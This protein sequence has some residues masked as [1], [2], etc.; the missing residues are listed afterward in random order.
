MRP[1]TKLQVFA[2]FWPP[3]KK[4]NFTT[5]YHPPYYPDYFLSP[6]LKTKLKGLHF[7]DVAE[8]QESV[9][10]ELKKVQK[11]E[12]SAALQKLYDRANPVYM[13]MELILNIKKARVFLTCLRFKKKVSR[14][15]VPHCV[16]C[17]IWDISQI[18]NFHLN[19]SIHLFQYKY[20]EIYE[21]YHK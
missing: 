10:E 14:T 3:P 21:R 8:I 1:P 20:I 16:Y 5:F 18:V 9:T 4:K 2:N 19:F 6:K 7:A 11:E 15:F 13:Q 17:N 12:F